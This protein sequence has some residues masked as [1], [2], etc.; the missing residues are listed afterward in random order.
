MTGILGRGTTHP[1]PF[2]LH[3]LVNLKSLKVGHV[4]GMRELFVCNSVLIQEAGNYTCTEGRLLVAMTW[5]DVET[6]KSWKMNARCILFWRVSRTARDDKHNIFQSLAAIHFPVT[7]LATAYLW[8]N[9]L[10]TLAKKTC[11][12]GFWSISDSCDLTWQCSGLQEQMFSQNVYSL[13]FGKFTCNLDKFHQFINMEGDWSCQNSFFLI[14]KRDSWCITG[15]FP[16]VPQSSQT[17][18]LGFPRNTP[19]PWTP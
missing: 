9:P 11:V 5:V 7:F 16:K 4:T 2:A 10:D 1:C 12:Y 3:F 8:A 17:E 15:L 14:T 6:W 18:S 19:S 13:R